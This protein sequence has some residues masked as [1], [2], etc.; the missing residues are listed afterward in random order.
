MFSPIPIRSTSTAGPILT[1][2]SAAAYIVASAP[3]W[4]VSKDKW[5]SKSW[6]SASP[7][8]TS[9]V[10]QSR[11][12]SIGAL[13]GRSPRYP[14]GWVEG[15]RLGG[16]M[17]HPER[18]HDSPTGQLAGFA[19]RLEY[20]SIPDATIAHAKLSVLDTLGCALYGQSLPWI[21]ML[22]DFVLSE[23]GDP[24]A[25]LW[26]SSFRV[27]R[28]QAA[29]VNATAAHSFEIDDIHMGGMIH[30]GALALGAA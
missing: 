21:A 26:G 15:S 1:S 6:P 18:E 4:L 22:R 20:P 5:S 23:G 24:Q 10:P 9:T 28:T 2:G 27:A 13:S 17:S 19:S 8:W 30:P 25:T 3:H 12:I 16:R 14:Y 7:T 29:L 11:P